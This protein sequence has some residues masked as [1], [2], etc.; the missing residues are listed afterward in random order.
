[1]STPDRLLYEYAVV[2][3]VPHIHREEFINIGL[4]MLC[5]R[6]R[7][8]SARIELDSSRIEAFDPG[9][10]IRVL[11]N[12]ASLFEKTYNPSP[13]LPV[14]ERYRWLTAA[15]SAMLQTSASHPGVICDESDTAPE[16]L[17][18]QEFDRLFSELVCL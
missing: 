15:K 12:Q 1:M 6:Q 16:L 3:Y 8:I 4:L 2:R 11:E 5:K 17:L 9:V 14:E 13:E 18:S 7:W 10:N